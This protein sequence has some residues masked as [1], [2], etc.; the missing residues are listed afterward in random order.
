M[1]C[2]AKD[3]KNRI[4]EVIN[5]GGDESAFARIMSLNPAYFISI[6]N[7][8]EKGISATVFKALSKINVNINWLITGEGDLKT[9]EKFDNK[10]KSWKD[11]AMAAEKTIT[12]YERDIEN[13]NFLTKGSAISE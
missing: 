6:L 11:R 2:K 8:P 5:N 10:F 13:L 4:R 9:G 12:R 3:I 7:S 1:F